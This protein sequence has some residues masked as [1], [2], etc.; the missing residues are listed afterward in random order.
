MFEV[1][2]E[3]RSKYIIDIRGK[4]FVTYEGL[5]QAGKE[6]GIQSLVADPVQLPNAENEMFAVCKA[7]LEGK[8]GSTYMDVGDASPKNVNARVK[9]AIL[10]MAATRA[11]ARV[12]RD[13]TGLAMCSVEEL[14][15]LRDPSSRD[16]YHDAA[17]APF[18]ADPVSSPSIIRK[19]RQQI[20][21]KSELGLYCQEC[22]QEISAKVA[23]FS[24]DRYK[25]HLC[26]RCQ[27]EEDRMRAS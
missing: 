2:N 6:I 8:D 9:D 24:S 22:G 10:R 1:T 23:S 3:F 27:R 25:R 13:F 17:D 21:S 4:D 16:D 11:K 7:T 15:D 19:N 12:L 14:G 26:M 20:D 5:L 18:E